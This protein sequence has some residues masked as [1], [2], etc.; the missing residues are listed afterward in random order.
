MEKSKKQHDRK[1]SIESYSDACDVSDPYVGL[2]REE[3][4]RRKKIYEG[5]KKLTLWTLDEG[6]ELLIYPEGIYMTPEYPGNPSEYWG[7]YSSDFFVELGLRWRPL[8]RAV[9]SDTLKVIG[10]DKKNK[11]IDPG[12]PAIWHNNF[13]HCKVSPFEFLEFVKKYDLF[14]IPTDLEWIK[15][16]S[17]SG[18]VKYFWKSDG[19][20]DSKSTSLDHLANAIELEPNENNDLTGKERQELGRLRSE[21]KAM[22]ASVKAAIE[23]GQFIQKKAEKEETII[24]K[25][26]DDLVYEIDKNIP[27]TWIN[28]IWKSIP[29]DFK[30][31]PGR[32][33]K[34]NK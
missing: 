33:K 27:N 18:E 10:F 3:K 9:Q 22:D 11:E 23:V 14:N 5:M 4:S 19:E 34:T 16:V 31:G 32:P 20:E 21:K 30:N 26:I 8:A 1:Y 12:E 17:E 13:G 29:D 24:R 28:F 6:I 25:D 7:W 2:D 15:K